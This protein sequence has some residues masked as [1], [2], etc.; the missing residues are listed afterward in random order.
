MKK[1]HV[2]YIWQL[3]G[4]VILYDLIPFPA[5]SSNITI[6][7]SQNKEVNEKGWGQMCLLAGMWISY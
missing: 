1:P 2:I 5:I 6:H 7:W 4:D 3:V